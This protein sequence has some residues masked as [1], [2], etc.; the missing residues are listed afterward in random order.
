MTGWGLNTLWL[1]VCHHVYRHPLASIFSISQFDILELMLNFRVVSA[2]SR[3]TRVRQTGRLMTL[4]DPFC[5]CGCLAVYCSLERFCSTH[6]FSHWS[7]WKWK[8][9]L[10]HWHPKKTSWQRLHSPGGQ[11]PS[12]L[13]SACWGVTCLAASIGHASVYSLKPL[14]V[15]D[16]GKY[17]FITTHSCTAVVIYTRNVYEKNTAKDDRCRLCFG[18]FNSATH[19]DE[20]W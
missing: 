6:W 17:L 1:L 18:R 8:H 2:I 3:I 15:K 14:A 5:S 4:G 12:Y 9:L 7:Q 13:V 20:G 10:R 19:I 11:P 16:I